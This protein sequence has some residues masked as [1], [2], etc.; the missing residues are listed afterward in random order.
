MLLAS[1]PSPMHSTEVV[2]VALAFVH[3]SP[4]DVSIDELQEHLESDMSEAFNSMHMANASL[5]TCNGNAFTDSS[6]CM[7]Y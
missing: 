5:L 2:S 4:S 6:C 7:G 1:A 3:K